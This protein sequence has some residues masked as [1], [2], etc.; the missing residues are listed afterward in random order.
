[1][2]KFNGFSGA[3]GVG[4]IQSGA[5]GA[6]KNIQLDDAKLGFFNTTAVVQPSTTGENTGFTAGSGTA[7]NDDSTFTGNVGST[8]Y[9]IS[10]LVEHLKN[11]GLI[12]P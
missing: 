7:V 12:A 8:A 11:L 5:G 4:E 3:I 1:M 2:S 10:D 6:H 9:R